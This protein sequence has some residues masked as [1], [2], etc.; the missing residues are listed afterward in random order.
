MQLS[1]ALPPVLMFIASQPEQN[2][3]VSP[4][5]TKQEFLE[6][7]MESY[8]YKEQTCLQ[9]LDSTHRGRSIIVPNYTRDQGPSTMAAHLSPAE[10]EEEILRSP[11]L[12]ENLAAVILYLRLDIWLLESVVALRNSGSMELAQLHPTLFNRP[13]EPLFHLIYTLRLFSGLDLGSTIERIEKSAQRSNCGKERSRETGGSRVAPKGQAYGC[14]SRNCNRAFIKSGHASNHVE[15]QHPEYLKLHPDYHPSHLMVDYQRSRPTSPEAERQERPGPG[16]RPHELRP[17]MPT[18]RALS[19]TSDGLAISFSDDT[20]ARWDRPSP[21]VPDYDSPWDSDEGLRLL[22]SREAPRNVNYPSPSYSSVSQEY[23]T[24]YG[25]D[26]SRYHVPISAFKR[27]RDHNS[28]TESVATV[29][30][31]NE[32]N[33]VRGRRNVKRRSTSGLMHNSLHASVWVA[34]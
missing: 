29:G 26:V 16:S 27:G 6:N 1:L 13:P 28:S 7:S 12:Q 31:T 8:Y 19:G 10:I 15:K 33:P 14:P 2:S 3:Q 22:P 25:S 24:Y 4:L 21:A 34:Q 30:Y 32:A 5:P 20:G 18:T 9:A 11:D 23:Q 17:H